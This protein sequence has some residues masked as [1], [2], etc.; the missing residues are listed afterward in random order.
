MFYQESN[1]FST[2]QS[3]KLN[4]ARTLYLFNF[5]TLSIAN[6]INNGYSMAVLLKHIIALNYSCIY[7][8][9]IIQEATFYLER[10]AYIF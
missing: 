7:T 3:D 9:T 10:F 2:H 8:Y 1:A 4:F 6:T 5:I